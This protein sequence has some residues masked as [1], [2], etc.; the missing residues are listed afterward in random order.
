MTAQPTLKTRF[1]LTVYLLRCQW[2]D[3]SSREGRQWSDMI[4][5]LIL[6]G[7]ADCVKPA[8]RDMQRHLWLFAGDPV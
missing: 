1:P 5:G 7:E 4:T 3:L 8:I 2:E 6:G